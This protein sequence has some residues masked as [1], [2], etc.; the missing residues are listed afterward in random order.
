MREV[1]IDLWIVL[2]RE[3]A[4]DPVIETMLPSSWM[5][6]R[7]RTVLVFHDTGEAVERFAV[8]RYAVDG[9]FPKAWDPD[10]QPDQM[11]RLAELVRERDP[12]T[13]ALNVSRTFALAD[14]LTKSQYDE[15]VE[16]LGS[17]LAQRI[18]PARPLAL[19]W[20]ETRS[21]RELE[22]YPT[23]CRIAHAIIAEGL[24]ERAIQPGATSTADLEWWFRERVE[25]LDLDT[26]FH[27][28]VSVQRPE[29]GASG[30][31]AEGPEVDVIQRGDLVHVDFGITYLG[32]NTD[33]QQHAYVLRLG[34]ESAPAGLV[35]GLARAN[36]LQEILNGHFATGRS[37][38]EVLALAREQ[39]VAEGLEP[40]IYTHPLGNHGHGAGPLIGLWDSQGGVPGRGD[41]L[42]RPSTA[43]SIE[44]NAA[45]PV[46]EWDGMTVALHAR[47]GRLVR[48]LDGALAG[49]SADRALARPMTSGRLRA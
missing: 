14:G 28:S 26:W 40:S 21:E 49:R 45:V 6:A 27:P 25:A 43:W 46:P 44:L 15:L 24:S 1:G 10:E 4:E 13:I 2:A 5:A 33:T 9:L 29:S 41:V 31:F 42:L 22:L 37:G 23:L 35:T 20:L 18:V 34:E 3:Y 16:A 12:R 48:R 11:A 36:R 47:G 7:R 38:N 30:S 19:A 32:L 17:E 8:A 39:A